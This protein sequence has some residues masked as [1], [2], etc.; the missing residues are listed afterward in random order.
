MKEGDVEFEQID[1]NEVVSETL[2][3]SHSEL[4]AR[5]TNVEFRRGKEQVP[6]LGNFTQLQQIVLNLLLNAAD[7][8]RDLAPG[9][10]H[11][12]VE[13]RMLADGTRQLAVSDH[14]PGLS[15]EAA[16]DAFKPF[17]TSR[18]DGLGL[19]LSICRSI[20]KAHGGTLAFEH[21]VEIG[22]RIVLALPEP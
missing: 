12:L 9:Q 21:D 8:M 1:L 19:G 6:V 17:V 3:L 5:H 18:P 20:A 22:A 10:R 14:G 16:S 4:V 13:T 11:V 7:A 2:A 15:A